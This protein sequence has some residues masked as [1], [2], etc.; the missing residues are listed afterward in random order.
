MQS[1]SLAKRK[2]RIICRLSQGFHFRWDWMRFYQRL[3]LPT[4]G[5]P[6]FG[7]PP[8]SAEV[9]DVARF[10]RHW[11]LQTSSIFDYIPPPLTNP[12]QMGL[13][14]K[15]YNEKVTLMLPKAVGQLIFAKKYMQIEQ[16]LLI[17]ERS[18]ELAVSSKNISWTVS[19]GV[20]L[21][22]RGRHTKSEVVFPGF[23]CLSQSGK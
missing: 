19:E 15:W 10:R 22:W 23:I 11:N 8:K 21:V 5:G 18:K 3:F 7:R 17:L 2:G 12:I 13:M 9:T 4:V 1:P 6:R 14:T 16:T 20:D